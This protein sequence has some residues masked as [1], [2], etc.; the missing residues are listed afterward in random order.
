MDGA[1]RRVDSVAILLQMCSYFYDRMVRVMDERRR[2]LLKLSPLAVTTAAAV[3]GRTALAEAP[4]TLE[5]QLTFNVRAYG[6]SGD[7]KTVD[8][9]AINHAIE[10][11][12]AAG[13]GLLVFPAGT[14][15][16]FTIHL[17]SKVDLYLSR[18]C[19]ILAADSTKPG[20]ATGHNGGT[21][22]AAEPNE[23]WD[24]FQDYGHSHWRNSLFVGEAIADFAIL[25][26][27]LIHGK[28]LSRGSGRGRDYAG[29][30]SFV[31]EQ[32]GVGDK[33]IALKNCHNVVLRDF[34]V[35]K[36]GHFALLASR[37][38]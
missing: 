14:Y 19:T 2:N 20:A 38:E 15:L 18:G 35:L 3:I 30:Y 36:G 29:N 16:C 1:S 21:Y 25:G 9:P 11:V 4:S 34:T 23:P 10:A 5:T 13:G 17:R 32:P 33:A 7:G 27:G 24:A 31:A 8:T 22:D 28:G 6:A 37:S 12:A 26:P